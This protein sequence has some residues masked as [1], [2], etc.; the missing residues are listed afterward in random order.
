MNIFIIIAA[1][2]FSTHSADQRA[3]QARP[4]VEIQAPA[5]VRI[6]AYA[7]RARARVTVRR[8]LLIGRFANGI[9]VERVSVVQARGGYVLVLSGTRP[10]RERRAHPE[11]ASC[12]TVSIPLLD[13]R[14]GGLSL[15]LAPVVTNTCTGVNCSQC[16]YVADSGCECL[17]TANPFGGNSDGICNHT[18]T[19][20]SGYAVLRNPPG[21]QPR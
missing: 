14:R 1:M 8:D 11:A 6:A 3:E 5:S 19:T 16:N 21:G 12:H 18:Q 9:P 10:E 7:P 4:R 15:R 13:D 17:R 2:F 20:T